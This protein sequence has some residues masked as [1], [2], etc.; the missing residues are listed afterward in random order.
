MAVFTALTS[1]D[2]EIILARYEL[3][4]LLAFSPISSGIENTNYFVDTRKGGKIAS[5]VL[6]LFE[7]LPVSELPYFVELTQRLAAQGL[8]VPAAEVDRSGQAIFRAADK[9]GVLVPKLPGRA[10]VRPRCQHAVLLGEW[11]ARMHQTASTSALRRKPPRDH[12]WFATRTEQLLPLLPSDDRHLLQS[13]RTRLDIWMTQLDACPK[14]QI[15]GDLFRDNVLFQSGRISGVIDFYHS[16]HAPLIFDVAVAIN[17][18][19]HEASIMQG[20]QSVRALH[21]LEWEALPVARVMAAW[22]FW[23][24]RLLTKHQSGYQSSSRTGV[25][26]KE[27]DEMKWLVQNLL[28]GGVVTL[29]KN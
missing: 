9:Y 22:S 14:G 19:Q 16:C 8:C 21:P 5:W 28:R 18:W 23:L 1:R 26:T 6:T 12:E 27:P 17:D 4:A 25:V 29:G 2:I 7:N 13:L 24:S 20:Y 15:H 3:G 11:L 10:L